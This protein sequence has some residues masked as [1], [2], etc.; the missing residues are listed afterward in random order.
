MFPVGTIP[1]SAR[2]VSGIFTG[3]FGTS[4]FDTL[5]LVASTS[6]ARTVYA[7]PDGDRIVTYP[8]VADTPL[9]AVVVV[10]PVGVPCKVPPGVTYSPFGI[11]FVFVKY[12]IGAL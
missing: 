11:A 3:V 9:S 2:T 6:S 1:L 8:L 12:T 7:N 10:T 4:I 5:A